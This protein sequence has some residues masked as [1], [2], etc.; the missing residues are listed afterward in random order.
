MARLG[1]TLVLIH[2][3]SWKPSRAVLRRL[4]IDALRTGMKRDFP[5]TENP[6]DGVRVE[7]V[8]FGDLSNDYLERVRGKTRPESAKRRRATL[9]SLKKLGA[10]DFTKERYESLPGKRAL[11][12]AL[13]DVFSPVLP[14]FQMGEKYVMATAP[15]MAEYWNTGADF[16]S[17]VRA[18]ILAPLRR[19]LKRGDSVAIVGHSL[20][21]VIAYDTLWKFT[22]PSGSFRGRVSISIYGMRRWIS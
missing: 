15:D 14:F 18:P 20:G 6:F 22:T 19:A 12:E 16:G 5:E 1:K 2:G 3:R 4:W 7:V 8:Y 17:R 10:E 13:A 21:S 9:A 11:K